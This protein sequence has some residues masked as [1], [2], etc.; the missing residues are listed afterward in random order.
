MP[1]RFSFGRNWQRYLLKLDEDRIGAAVRSL[2]ALVMGETLAGRSFLDIGCGSGLFSLAARRLGASVR[3][4]DYD[5]DSVAC[6]EELRRRYFANDEQWIIERGSI[7]D[8]A[9]LNTLPAFDVVYSWGVF[10][11]TGQMWEAMANVDALVAPGGTLCLA[12]Y[13]DQGGAT[14]R[15]RAIKRLYNAVPLVRWPLVLSIGAQMELKQ[16]AIRLIRLQNPLP[17]ADWARRER[18]RGMSYWHDLVDWVG[19]YPFEA[20]KPEEVFDFW[21]RRGYE[22]RRM[23]T[24]GCGHGC[25]EF[26][27]VKGNGNGGVGLPGD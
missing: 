9:Y 7:L 22:L 11:H 20:A 26:T 21:R 24:Q 12:I 18:E 2:Q 23:T 27:F 14:R 8:A 4:F 5:E 13:N 25:N 16:M 17:F 6:C 10:H 3:S 19:G 1:E 15:W